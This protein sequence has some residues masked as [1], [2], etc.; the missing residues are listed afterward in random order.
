[1]LHR[2]L[3]PATVHLEEGG[4][5]KLV[6]FGLARLGSAAA[7]LS[8]DRD[9][10]D[11]AG[12]LP[13]E[14]ALGLEA[15]ARTDVY[16]FGALAHELLAGVRP[17]AGEN[18][19]ELVRQALGKDPTSL[20]GRWPACPPELSDLVGRCLARD[21]GERYASFEP[22]SGEL[23]AILEEVRLRLR[24]PNRATVVAIDSREA[25]RATA[26]RSGGGSLAAASATAPLPLAVPLDLSAQPATQP[27]SLDDTMAI[28]PDLIVGPPPDSPPALQI[29]PPEL[30]L[31]ELE[32]EE[33]SLNTAYLL[34]PPGG[35]LAAVEAGLADDGTV[36][37]E[38]LKAAAAAEN[39]VRTEAAAAAPAR[40][41]AALP[42]KSRRRWIALALVALAVLATGG[43]W[44]ASQVGGLRPAPVAPPRPAAAS[45]PRPAVAPPTGLLVVDASPWAQ[46]TAVVDEAGRAVPLPVNR[47]TPL[48][49]R[50][51]A[52]R[53]EA[54]L[55]RPGTSNPASCTTVV[56][57]GRT[58]QC[59]AALGRVDVTDYFK[60]AGWWR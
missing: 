35:P 60:Q 38:E 1:V 49:I 10:L 37:V 20:L 39:P 22:I 17:F 6:D 59:R 2:D 4:Q 23:Q 25:R 8:G 21:P 45:A 52:G 24:R 58:A 29:E 19:P 55:T 47:F 27:V 12:Y 3:K 26:T 7:W 9:L 31:P 5:V 15:D 14:L 44:L 34:D 16:C 54:T 50:L 11:A 18:L 40:P 36:P 53:Y 57:V 46:V 48:A 13:P 43:W 56:V 33:E 32:P 51:P 28:P 42:G 30:E 41:A